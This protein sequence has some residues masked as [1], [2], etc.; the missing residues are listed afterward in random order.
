MFYHAIKGETAGR[1]WHILGLVSVL[2]R[3]MKSL[4]DV[5]LELGWWDTFGILVPRVGELL[6]SCD[7]CCVEVKRLFF[8]EKDKLALIYIFKVDLKENVY[9]FDLSKAL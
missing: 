1:V 8:S 7:F 6:F 4:I 5:I 3:Q 9:Q 2:R